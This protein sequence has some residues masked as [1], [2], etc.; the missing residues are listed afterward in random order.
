MDA[1]LI[2][3]KSV[4]LVY[5]IA[6]T[7]FYSTAPRSELVLAY[8]MYLI[9]NVAVS[10][11]RPPSFRL[12]AVLGSAALIVGLA[13]RLD[14]A[15]ILL[16]PVNLYE[17]GLQLS[18]RFPLKPWM[19][20]AFMA[21]PGVFVER[22][23]MPSYWLA[24]MLGFLALSASTLYVT[25][26]GRLEEERDRLQRERHQ[27]LRKLNEN[28]ELQ[29]QAA[30][31]VQLEERSRL[32]QQIHDEVG[33]AMA[34]ALMQLEAAKRVLEKDRVQ[35]EQ[36]MDNAIR[37]SRQ[38]LE[39]IRMT[40]KGL[41][42]RPEE[43]GINRLRLLADELSARHGITSTVTHTGDL[44]L[45]TPLQWSIIQQN[46]Y[47]AITNSLKYAEASH[48]RLEVHVLNRLIR[49]VVADNGKGAGKVKKGLGILGMEER[50]ASAGGTVIVDGSRGFSV[51]TLLPIRQAE[52]GP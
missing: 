46:A 42:P 19:L 43:M 15:F 2:G 49:F 50:A 13:V 45:I 37:I 39:Q 10:V 12:A 20:L 3:S 30:Y 23:L 34:G 16:L 27:L 35:A 28:R 41:K 32:S 4:L 9:L 5:V 48:I 47:E 26:T 24:S 29:R 6:V 40:L 18:S 51:I 44:D 21:L 11:I 1:W 36:L 7:Y 31:T 14:P 38:G 8:L 52:S 22:T 33:H 25:R 17:L